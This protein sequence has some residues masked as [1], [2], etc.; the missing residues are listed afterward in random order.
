MPA[1][2]HKTFITPG[3]TEDGGGDELPRLL[4][5]D[6]QERSSDLRESF[7]FPLLRQNTDDCTDSLI[8]LSLT[9]FTS[10]F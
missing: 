5:S 3:M 4:S 1:P 8:Q 2:L 6:V 7:S 10:H 9:L